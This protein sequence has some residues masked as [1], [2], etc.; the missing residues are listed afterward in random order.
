[1]NRPILRPAWSSLLFLVCT[2]LFLG[3]CSSSEETD[4]GPPP[5]TPT[6]LVISDLTATAGTASTVT[7]T[8][9]SPELAD[10]ATIQYDLRHIAYGSEGADWDSWTVAAA[11]GSDTES[12]RPRTYEVG[13]LASGQAYV[14]GMTA[15][16]DGTEWSAASNITVATAAPVFDTT[17]PA[18][19]TGLFLYQGTGTSLTV[20][21]PPTGDDGTYGEATSYEARYSATPI[22]PGNWGAATPVPGAITESTLPG[23]MET[24]VTGLIAD[25]EYHLAVTAIDDQDLVSGLS[26]VVTAMTV[27]LRTIYVDVSGTGDYP[28]IEA[29]IHAA[30]AGD[31]ILVGPGRYTWANQAT[32]DSL[33]GLINVPRDYTDFEVRSI[34]GPEATILDA[35]HHGKVM[36]VTGGFSGDPGDL[37]YAG[38]TIEGFTFTNGQ[39]NA[40]E[41][42][43][44]EGWSGG[45]L[46]LHLSD[47]V[48]R[49]CIFTG[50]EATEGGALWVGGQG[51]AVIENC[52]FENNNG[53]VGGAILL[54]NSEPRIT[55]RNCVIRNNHATL[56][57]G[58]IFA[59]NVTATL[60]DL[61]IVGNDSSNKGGGIS[62]SGL[63]PDCQVIRCTVVGNEAALG[64]A[65]RLT[66]NT[67]L[68]IESSLLAF[69]TGSAA[70]SAA[71]QSGVEIGC[72][73]VFGHDL[74]NQFPLIHT[75]LGDNLETDP[76]FCDRVDYMLQGDS[77]CL[78]GNHPDGADCGLIGA[79]GAGC[80][81]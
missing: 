37:N 47:T 30:T 56:A 78:P 77:P 5:P 13:G 43:P 72:T 23:T 69:N 74:G 20:A 65:I 79:R 67:M 19:V 11:P 58:G 9:T 16:T 35:Q 54:I 24:T 1:M 64:S 60:E 17:P 8:W 81:R 53:K 6:P 63:H 28:T 55:V 38:I 36:S 12:G 15:S 51:D 18:A 10:K 32:G 73:L 40:V 27:D 61:L 52:L 14:F 68:R 2:A 22:N 49:N 4:P 80:G 25:Q 50:N 21:W 33:L 76:L 71:V 29:A 59:I 41:P 26:N 48:V 57:G 39:A 70:F 45:G 44:N 66:D 34:A 3:A 75:D 31:L 62:V 7:L 46:N 42:N